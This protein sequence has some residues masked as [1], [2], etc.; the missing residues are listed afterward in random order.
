MPHT[1]WVLVIAAAGVIAAG[2]STGTAWAGGPGGVIEENPHHMS[3][4]VGTGVFEG[5]LMGFHA[6]GHTNDEAAAA[7]IAVCQAAGG[8]ECTA[9]QVTNDDLCIVS[10]ADDNSDVVAGGAGVTVEAAR[11]DAFQRA[12]AN[13][14]PLAPTSPIVIADCH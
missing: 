1:R 4:A 5:D 13:N 7:V 12:A 6:T 14:M 9:D 3:E 10:V 8:V 11:A 2:L